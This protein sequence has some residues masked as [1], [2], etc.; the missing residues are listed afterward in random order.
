GGVRGAG[1]GGGPGAAR[2]AG[3]GFGQGPV[4]RVGSK[5]GRLVVCCSLAGGG[6]MPA[7]RP[8]REP[9]AGL[10]YLWWMSAPMFAVF[11][12][13]S[14]KTGGGEPNWPVTAYVSG[15]VLTAGWLDCQLRSPVAWYRRLTIAGLA[16][17]G[18]VGLVLT[19]RR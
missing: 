3:G 7:H 5:W 15:L 12:A 18:G 8:W 4:V 19:V 13:F 11:L 2:G 16:A 1:G 17:A 9:D 10:R 14:P 6:A